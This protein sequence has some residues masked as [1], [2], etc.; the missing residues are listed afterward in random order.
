MEFLKPRLFVPATLCLF[1][2]A[3]C[4]PHQVKSEPPFVS[5]A[6]LAI[7]G[8]VLSARFDIRNINDVAMSID[9]IDLTIRSRETDLANVMQPLDLTIDPNTTEELAIDNL[10][11][12]S[13]GPLL[14]ELESGSVASLPFFLEGRVHTLEDGHLP[15]RHEGYLYPVPGKPGQFRS[16]SSRSREQP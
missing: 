12:E 8:Q 2:C 10:S 11:G 5:I 4:G 1:L 13:A 16:A 3:A 6:A 14:A 9:S 15:F 7:S